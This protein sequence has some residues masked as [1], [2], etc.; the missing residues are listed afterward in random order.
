MRYIAPVSSASAIITANNRA[1]KS[2]MDITSIAEAVIEQIEP[3][4]RMSL[5]RLRD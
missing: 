3:N 2:D 4:I 1:E 5:H